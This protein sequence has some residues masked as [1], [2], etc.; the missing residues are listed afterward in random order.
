MNRTMGNLMFFHTENK[1]WINQT[2]IATKQYQNLKG[3]DYLRTGLFIGFK[4]HVELIFQTSSPRSLSTES[5][6][7]IAKF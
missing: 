1:Q 7:L 5:H 6:P 4:K 2:N 3:G